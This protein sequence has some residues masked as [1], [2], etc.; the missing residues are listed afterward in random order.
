MESTVELK[1]ELRMFTGTEQWYQHGLVR[2]FMYTDGVKYFA[3]NAGGGAYWLLDI[4]ATEL[5]PKQ[6][7]YPFIA[8]KFVVGKKNAITATDGNDTQIYSKKIDYTDCPEGTWEFYL[9]D[10]I[11]LLTSEY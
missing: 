3:E 1:H 10:N 4:L 11:L 6:K 7:K 2:A 5:L 9:I 8:V